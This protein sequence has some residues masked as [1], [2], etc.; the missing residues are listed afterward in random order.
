MLIFGFADSI[1]CTILEHSSHNAIRYETF[2]REFDFEEL[3]FWHLSNYQGRFS[4]LIQ[5]ILIGVLGIRGRLF[6]PSHYPVSLLQFLSSLT[7]ALVIL[8]SLTQCI[9]YCQALNTLNLGE[10]C[11]VSSQFCW[12]SR[13]YLL[14][15]RISQSGS[16]EYC[17]SLCMSDMKA[18]A[19]PPRLEIF[20]DVHCGIEGAVSALTRCRHLK[21]LGISSDECSWCFSCCGKETY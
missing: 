1:L 10:E 3:I 4:P 7:I 5:M 12:I 13:R 15:E 6:Q 16:D 19:S 9:N 11:H 21:H 8:L 14:L 2:G 20:G 17:L 18:I